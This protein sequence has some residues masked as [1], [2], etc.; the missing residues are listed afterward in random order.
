MGLD[1]ITHRPGDPPLQEFTLAVTQAGAG[2]GTVT[3][4]PAGIDCGLM[5]TASFTDNTIVTLTANPATESVFEGWSGDADCV[6]GTV[7]MTADMDCTA[8]FS[9]LAGGD[10]GSALRFFGNGI[11]APDRDRVKIQVDDFT[12]ASDPFFPMDVGNQD[13][14]IE[15]WMRAMAAEN[16]ASAVACGP[17]DAWINGNIVIDRDRFNQDRKFGLSIAGGTLVF[18]VSGDGTGEQTICG[19]TMVLDGEWH[20]VAIQRDRM[21]GF[22][23]LFVD[24]NLDVES[25]GPNGDISYP[26]DGVPGNFCTGRCV[27]SDPYLVIGAEKHDAGAQFLSY[28]GWFDEMRVSNVLRYSGPFVRPS[29]PFV[30]DADTVVLYHFDEGAGEVVRDDLC[31]ANGPRDGIVR[32]GGNPAGP[33]WVQSDA[34]LV[35]P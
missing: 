19:T 1:D 7:T 8:T 29:A 27:D 4:E 28:S 14:T 15:F 23:Q 2:Q 13:F 9:A 32:F 35:I 24:G 31:P 26:D 20:H 12:T 22:M 16:T 34:P 18:G 11:A 21:N 3:S 10:A 17:N 5:C 25:D 33:V 6:D 30:R